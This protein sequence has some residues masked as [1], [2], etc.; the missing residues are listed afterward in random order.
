MSFGVFLFIPDK[1]FVSFPP[2]VCTAWHLLAVFLA[3]LFH[4]GQ[5]N[6]LRRTSQHRPAISLERRQAIGNSVTFP[7]HVY[8]ACHLLAV[9]LASLFHVGQPNQLRRT[10]Q[11]R[12]AS[13]RERRRVIGNSV[14]FPPHVCTAWH[15]LAVFLA[16]FHVVALI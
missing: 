13:S 5:P 16:L 8:T 7:P 1:S 2:H 11:H 3:S 14:T 15:L 9:F 12:P 6:Q 4:V 10:S